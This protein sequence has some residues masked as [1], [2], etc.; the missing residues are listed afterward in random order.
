MLEEKALML[1]RKN[2]IIDAFFIPTKLTKGEW[3]KAFLTNFLNTH[4]DLVIFVRNSAMSFEIS[5]MTVLSY[6]VVVSA[7]SNALYRFFKSVNTN[8]EPS[9][10]LTLSSITIKLFNDSLCEIIAF[11]I[12]DWLTSAAIFED[13]YKPSIQHPAKIIAEV[14]GRLLYFK[15]SSNII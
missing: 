5:A 9:S 11:M 6:F 8:S 10:S 15:I 4:Y 14:A 2:K 1:K 3:L 7:I 12:P 13:T